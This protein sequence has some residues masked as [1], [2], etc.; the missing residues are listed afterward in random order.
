ME[1]LNIYKPY[2]NGFKAKAT[3][4]CVYENFGGFWTYQDKE[5]NDKIKQI[6]KEHNCT[7]YAVTH[8]YTECDEL[9]DMLV[10][11]DYPEE[12]DDLLQ[13][14]GD[15][16]YAFAYCWNKGDEFN[17]EFGDIEVASFGGGIKRIG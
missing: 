9:Y 7:V 3:K 14:S 11:T 4:V 15:G 10:V 6:E 2:I 17:S 12:W 5:L 16:Y 8:E 1:K 13:K